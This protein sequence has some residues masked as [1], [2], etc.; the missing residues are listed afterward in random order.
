[1]VSYNGSLR[2]GHFFHGRHPDEYDTRM[3]NPAM[4]AAL[5]SGRFEKALRKFFTEKWWTALQHCC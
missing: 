1:M 2:F 3:A 5:V 4:A